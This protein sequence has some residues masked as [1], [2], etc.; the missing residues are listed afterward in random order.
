M[1]INKNLKLV[2]LDLLWDL[3]SDVT[4]KEGLISK[5]VKKLNTDNVGAYDKSPLWHHIYYP[6][7]GVREKKDLI[8][9]SALCLA[10]KKNRVVDDITQ[11][12]I[13]NPL[14]SIDHDQSIKNVSKSLKLFFWAVKNTFP[15]IGIN[16]QKGLFYQT[17][18]SLL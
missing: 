2:D 15:S 16:A 3:S 11:S 18:V 12:N 9:M 4:E 14:Y 1:D 5:V 6:S 7:L 10:L 13:K 17:E 8:K